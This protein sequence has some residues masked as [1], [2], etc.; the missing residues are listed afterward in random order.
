MPRSRARTAWSAAAALAAALLAAGCTGPGH[1]STLGS[2]ASRLSNRPAAHPSPSHIRQYL[3]HSPPAAPTSRPGSQPGPASPT[4]PAGRPVAGQPGQ[5]VP[6]GPGPCPANGLRV[7]IA[8]AHSSAGSL[9]YPLDFTNVS[10]VTCTMY[11]YPGVFFATGPNGTPMG[12]PAVRNSGAVRKLVTLAPGLTAH[13]S[14]QVAVAQNYPP[15]LCK[16]VTAH[17][18]QV[19]PPA[20]YAADYVAFTALT[21]AG[22]VQGGTTLGIYVVRSG[23]TGP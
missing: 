18:L 9:Y 6:A 10:D 5:P 14:L 23:A 8:T 16:P 20:S 7:T 13:A 21:C 4:A 17:W 12:G 22:K 19:F 11:G 3:S 1:S 2:S 15:A